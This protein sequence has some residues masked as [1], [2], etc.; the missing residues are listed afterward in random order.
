MTAI[1]IAELADR[2]GVSR[3]TIHRM[4]KAGELP[5]TIQTNRRFVRWTQS[6]IQLWLDLNCPTTVEFT[7]L[8]RTKQKFA[9]R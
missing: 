6:D 8:K 5:P 1:T 3:M 7:A 9:R 4:R 2:L